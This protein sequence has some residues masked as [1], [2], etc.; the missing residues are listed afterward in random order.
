[1]EKLIETAEPGMRDELSGYMKGTVLNNREKKLL[2][3]ADRLAALIKCMEETAGGNGEFASALRSTKKL[4]DG[5]D[6]DEVRYFE[7]NMLPGYDLCL[8]ELARI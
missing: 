7:E 4:L 8:D 6:L 1:M 2:K 3:A 5:M